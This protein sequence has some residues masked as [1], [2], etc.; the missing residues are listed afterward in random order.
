M[1]CS[2]DGMLTYNDE[3]VGEIYERRVRETIAR[4]RLG[5]AYT[6]KGFAQ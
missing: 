6:H 2:D 4:W 3:G 1:V 5:L